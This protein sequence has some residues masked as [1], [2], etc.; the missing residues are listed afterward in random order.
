M[1]SKPTCSA[2]VVY[3]PVDVDAVRL[4][5]V[6]VENTVNELK[7]LTGKV[8]DSL[9]IDEVYA[10]RYNVVVLVEAL[11]SLA[12]HILVE[13]FGYRPR[14][15]VDAIE[16]LASRLGVRCVDELRALVRL[17]NLLVHRYWVVDDRRVYDDVRS[18]FTCIMDFIEAV[19]SRYLHG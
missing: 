2:L 4:R 1:L 15:Y 7:R 11:V 19:R 13:D 3:V 14:S 9:T 18:D 6:D 16:Q 5:V 10:I 8:F 17:R 12:V